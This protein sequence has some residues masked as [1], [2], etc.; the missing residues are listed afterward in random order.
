MYSATRSPPE[1]ARTVGEDNPYRIGNLTPIQM[2]NIDLGDI[3]SKR[4]SFTTEEWM[5]LLLRSAGYEPDSLDLRTKL[6][7][8]ERMVP[9]VERNYNLCELGPRG[10]GKSHIYNE[11]VPTPSCF[12]AGK[13]LQRTFSGD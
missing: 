2:P 7:F 4:K 12:P 1:R 3:I 13:R 9:L 6:H 10:T 5:D 8:I 11:V